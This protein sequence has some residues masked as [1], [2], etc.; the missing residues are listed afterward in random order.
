MSVRWPTSVRARTTA[1]ASLLVALFLALAAWLLLATL[2]RGL[3][4]AQDDATRGR[5]RG[6]AALAESGRLPARLGPF[7]EDTFAQIGA[8][9]GTL[10]ASSPRF[11]G[12]PLAE[13]FDPGPGQTGVRDIA[14]REGDEI[15][16]YRVW[17]VRAQTPDGRVVAYV[18]SS[19][20][21]VTEAVSTLAGLLL[22]GV[23]VLAAALAA[24]TWL[25]LGR[26]LHPVEA[27]R[28]KVADISGTG[29]DRRVPVPPGDDEIARLAR[30]MNEMLERLER[31][32][33]RLTAFT[34][35]ASHELLSPLAAFRTEIEVA[36]AHQEQTQWPE[37]AEAL[38]EQCHE[39][40]GLVRDLLFLAQ[41]DERSSHGPPDILVDLDDVVLEEA[42]RLRAVGSVVV[43]TTAVSAAPVRGDRRQLRRLVRNLLDNA[44]RHA[45]SRVD[46]RL[47]SAGEVAELVVLDDGPGV[48]AADRERIFERFVRLDDARARDTGG[49]GLGLAIV[50]AVAAHHGGSAEVRD[51]AQGA[52]FV[53]RFPAA[54]LDSPAGDVASSRTNDGSVH[55][56]R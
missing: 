49:A 16:D 43:D 14:V 28:S 9:D 20:E 33:R 47:G 4:Q 50:A 27:I 40:E 6:L 25:L 42:A 55:T 10:L 26:A 34:S 54:T 24:L 51:V 3:E 7:A 15:E 38:L 17:A 11:A 36:L 44:A 31:A 48:L 13:G 30:T 1:A 41:Q 46:V 22:L 29:L 32:T 35:D 5:L 45:A 37:M 21:S 12:R 52:A 19:R 53:V 23:P 39:M 8:A 18:G 2:E 56:R